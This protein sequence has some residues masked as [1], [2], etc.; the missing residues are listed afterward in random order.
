ERLLDMAIGVDHERHG[1]F[2]LEVAG[3]NLN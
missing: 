1:I 3:I 2:F